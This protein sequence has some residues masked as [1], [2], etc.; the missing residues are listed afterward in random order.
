VEAPDGSIHEQLDALADA[1]DKAVQIEQWIGTL[2]ERRALASKGRR[3][4][5]GRME[6]K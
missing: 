2:A 3:G 6:P 1:I 5:P 4:S